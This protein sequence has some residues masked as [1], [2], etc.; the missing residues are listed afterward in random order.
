MSDSGDVDI[1]RLL[2]DLTREL[3]VLKRELEREETAELSTRQQLSQFTSEV[4]IPGLILLLE[5]NIRALKLL[6]RTIRLAEGRDP[7]SQSDSGGEVRRRA[8]E[9]GAEALSRLDDTLARVQ[10]SLE[11][12]GANDEV[13]QLL[14]EARQLQETVSQQLQAD[15]PAN[16]DFDGSLDPEDEADSDAVTVDVD[17]ELQTLKENLD[18]EPEDDASD[19]NDDNDDAD[20]ESR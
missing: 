11:E 14:D 3:Q 12:G 6:R 16:A 19:D 7:R 5:T 9:L 15:E 17:A 4:A 20:G 8:D 13:Q 1:T 18:D 2:R 10:S